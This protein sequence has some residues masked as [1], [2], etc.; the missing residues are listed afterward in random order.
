[1]AQDAKSPLPKENT[2]AVLF[3]RLIFDAF[4]QIKEKNFPEKRGGGLKKNFGPA[5]GSKKARWGRDGAGGKNYGNASP[6]EGRALSPH[7]RQCRMK[8]KRS[9]TGHGE[10]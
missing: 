8:V 4:R 6:R 10:C 2:Q 9:K 7:A 3:S 5:G 1:M